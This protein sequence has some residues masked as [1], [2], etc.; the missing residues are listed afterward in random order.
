MSTNSSVLQRVSAMWNARADEYNQ[1]DTLDEDE[2]VTYAF[3]CG[4]AN[5]LLIKADEET[6]DE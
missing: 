3:I 5:E 4:K 6:G 1:W 2:K